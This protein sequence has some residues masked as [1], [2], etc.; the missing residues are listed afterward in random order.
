MLAMFWVWVNI[1]LADGFGDALSAYDAGDYDA[2]LRLLRPLAER[3]HADA[4]FRLGTMFDNGLGVP[5][6]PTQAEYWY[7]QA[8]PRPATIPGMDPN[9]LQ[10]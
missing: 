10:R 2:A 7:N 1:A 3:G 8:C 5:V 6:D 4:Q 9:E